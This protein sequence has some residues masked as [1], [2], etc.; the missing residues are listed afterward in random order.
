M[1]G[2][3]RWW[4]D[5]PSRHGL[6]V[7]ESLADKD[8]RWGGFWSW[9]EHSRRAVVTASLPFRQHIASLLV[10][11]LPIT[12]LPRQA[13]KNSYFW[14]TQGLHGPWTTGSLG[15]KMILDE[16]SRHVTAN[17]RTQQKFTRVPGPEPKPQLCL[18]CF[19]SSIELNQ[20]RATLLGKHL[21][22]PVFTG[23][24]FWKLLSL[25]TP[26]SS[27]DVIAQLD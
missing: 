18:P 11:S 13:F 24:W 20:R 3:C 5:E 6:W 8:W 12:A 27:V 2:I 15:K 19:S 9:K 10:L 25:W 4:E 23:M 14:H 16:A 22:F 21:D 17:L 1:G 26:N 7:M